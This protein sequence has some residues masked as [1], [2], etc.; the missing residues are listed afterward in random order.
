MALS[1]E[2]AQT[3]YGLFNPPHGDHF[4]AG[5]GLSGGVGF[6]DHGACKTELGRFAKAFLATWRRTYFARQTNFTKHNKFLW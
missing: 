1:V 6:G 5:Q 2:V 4:D 3:L